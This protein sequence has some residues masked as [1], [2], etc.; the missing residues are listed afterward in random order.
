M[1]S[2]INT[3]HTLLPPGPSTYSKDTVRIELPHNTC[4]RPS[5]LYALK[6]SRTDYD[7]WWKHVLSQAELKC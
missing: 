6:H 7:Y 2:V 4:P 1:V 3:S 5:S